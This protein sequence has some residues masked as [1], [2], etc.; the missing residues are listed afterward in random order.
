SKLHDILRPFLLRRL[1][2]D[3]LHNLPVKS[4]VVLYHGLSAL[5]KKQYKAILTR[6]ACE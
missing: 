5:Q 2:T 4:E 6:D 3:V 1:K